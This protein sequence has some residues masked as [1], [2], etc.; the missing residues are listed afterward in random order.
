[1]GVGNT[2]PDIRVSTVAAVI[3]AAVDTAAGSTTRE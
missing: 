2:A 1:M 3:L